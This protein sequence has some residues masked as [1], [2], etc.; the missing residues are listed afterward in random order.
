VKVVATLL[1]RPH[2]VNKEEGESYKCTLIIQHKN[3]E[4]VCNPN[5]CFLIVVLTRELTLT[6][7]N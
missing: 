2:I 6:T 5:A 3:L 4:I 7:S 1:L